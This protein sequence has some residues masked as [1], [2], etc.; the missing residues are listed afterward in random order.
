MTTLLGRQPSR[1]IAAL[2]TALLL[3]VGT[4]FA[5]MTAGAQARSPKETLDAFVLTPDFAKSFALVEE[6]PAA[7][8][9]SQVDVL[10]ST[11][12]AFEAILSLG[13]WQTASPDDAAL[14]VTTVADTLRADGWNITDGKP[15][16][17]GGRASLS[18][19]K[20][21]DEAHQGHVVIFQSIDRVGM[22]QIVAAP[23]KKL[24]ADLTN[25]FAALFLLETMEPGAV[26]GMGAPTPAP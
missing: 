14:V 3:L 2:S 10:R 22:A 25:A 9:S 4:V 20:T 5:P 19:D 12:T 11:D 16:D 23:D 24:E 7:D 15:E 21:F 18:G 1:R 13:V 26:P 6:Q 8:G 17:F